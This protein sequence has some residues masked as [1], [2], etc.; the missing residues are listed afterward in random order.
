[1][2]LTGGPP[3]GFPIHYGDDFGYVPQ[4]RPRPQPVRLAPQPTV[5]RPQPQRLSRPTPVRPGLTVRVEVPPPDDLG[6]RLDPDAGHAL[7]IPS[8]DDLGIDPN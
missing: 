1:V 6:I 8:P 4:S 5:A 7:V 2:P 3:V